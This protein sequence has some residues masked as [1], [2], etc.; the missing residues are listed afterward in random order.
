VDDAIGDEPKIPDRRV[1]PDEF[2][3]DKN[4]DVLSDGN[5]VLAF[6]CLSELMQGLRKLCFHRQPPLVIV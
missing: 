3:V 2:F 6:H 5:A 1:L 4:Q